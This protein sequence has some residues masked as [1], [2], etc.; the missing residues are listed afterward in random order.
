M[1]NTFTI[2]V[3][4][5]SPLV[6]SDFYNKK[7][8]NYTLEHLEN[9]YINSFNRMLELFD[10][11]NVKVTFFCVVNE[12]IKSEKIKD[13]I[14]L[15]L[16]KGHFIANHTYSHPFGLSELD[17]ISIK[18]EVSF[19]SEVLKNQFNVENIGFRTPGYSVNTNVVNILEELGLKYDSSAGW[20]IY[21]VIF[22]ILKFLK[23]SK[24][25]VGYG[26]TNLYLK[27]NNYI[28]SSKNW[29]LK[30]RKNRKI[31]EYPLPSSFYFLPCYSNFHLGLSFNFVKFL[32]RNTKIHKELIYL[33]HAIEFVDSTEVFVCKEILS[34]PHITKDYQTKII[35]LKKIINFIKKQRSY[36]NIEN[37]I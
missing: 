13:V 37:I 24:M 15:A 12:L 4:V 17:D 21:H 7:N 22:K 18:N 32:L 25:K 3:D 20:P 23:Y 9:F 16:N 36:F 6:L 29:Q 10:E 28:P 31:K 5:D 27:R 34:H 14:K 35:K 8:E 33:I 30:S 2:H 19:A 26:E 1:T 11:L